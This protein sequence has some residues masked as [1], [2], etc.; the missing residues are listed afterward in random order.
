[1]PTTTTFTVTGT[2]TVTTAGTA[3]T[4]TPNG[5]GDLLVDVTSTCAF[6]LNTTNGDYIVDGV[7]TGSSAT[8]TARAA[9]QQ[10]L[11]SLVTSDRSFRPGQPS[12]RPCAPRAARR[13]SARRARSATRSPRPRSPERQIRASRTRQP[14]TRPSR[15]RHAGYLPPARCSRSP[16]ARRRGVTFSVVGVGGSVGAD[17]PRQWPRRAALCVLNI[18]ATS[19][20][21]TVKT[22]STTAASS[23]TLYG[24]GV[25]GGIK[26]DM[27]STV[28]NGTAV[29]VTVTGSPA[30]IVNVDQQHDR[31][32]RPA[33]SWARARSRRSSSTTTA[34]TA[35]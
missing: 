17:R 24:S 11:S 29:N 23:I 26:L 25:V 34:R 5:V 12:R 10:S 19:C 8:A 13:A 30:I 1:M 32:T 28:P 15:R 35:A 18:G 16:S 20:S 31:H 33:S 14:A 7:D 6:E 2:P 4:V 3:G 22:A 21:V 9:G 27:A